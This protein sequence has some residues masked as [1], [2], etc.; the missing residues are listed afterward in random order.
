MAD[1][2]KGPRVASVLYSIYIINKSGGL[3]F[4]KVPR[5]PTRHSPPINRY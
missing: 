3:I 5:A 4:Q 2:S 1:A